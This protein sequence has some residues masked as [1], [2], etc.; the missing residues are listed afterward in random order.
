M[1]VHP[2][3]TPACLTELNYL[4]AAH[5]AFSGDRLHRAPSDLLILG[6][7][8]HT[9]SGLWNVHQATLLRTVHEQE[10]NA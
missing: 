9:W 2:S 10:T 3:L 7:S 4:R 6:A 1:P 5:L 8:T